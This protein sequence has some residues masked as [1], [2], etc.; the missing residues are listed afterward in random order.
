MTDKYT[1][2]DVKQAIADDGIG[3]CILSGFG[4]NYIDDVEL[5][6]LWDEATITLNAIIDYLETDEY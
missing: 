3:Y 4:S 6:K 5:A 1:I 2:E